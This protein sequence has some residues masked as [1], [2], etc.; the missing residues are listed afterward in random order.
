MRPTKA[1]EGEAPNAAP[2]RLSQAA[3]LRGEFGRFKAELRAGGL[4]ES[5]VHSYLVGSSLFVRWLA[6]E[7]VPGPGR[8]R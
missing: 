4:S 2:P 6:G 8:G 3:Y 5:T 1:R 7:Y